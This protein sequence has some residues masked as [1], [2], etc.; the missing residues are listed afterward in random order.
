MSAV[1]R[2]VGRVASWLVPPEPLTP[3]GCVR[4]LAVAALLFV[5]LV[6]GF[7]LLV[8]A[9]QALSALWEPALRTALVLAGN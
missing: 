5:L 1:R 3:L 7:W 2:A 8:I 9:L 4:S 6:A